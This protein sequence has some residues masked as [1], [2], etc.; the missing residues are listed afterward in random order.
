[1][2]LHLVHCC[3]KA[4]HFLNCR[5]TFVPPVHY[6]LNAFTALRSSATVEVEAINNK[7]SANAQNKVFCFCTYL[8]RSLSR[9]D[10]RSDNAS[11]QSQ[12]PFALLRS[13]ITTSPDPSTNQQPITFQLSA[14]IDFIDT[15]RL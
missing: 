3:N 8:V 12:K 6:L 7:D 4:L 10:R 2:L 11:A 1:M 9:P 15:Q 14:N 5:N 13:S